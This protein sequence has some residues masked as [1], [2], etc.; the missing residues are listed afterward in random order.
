M[1]IC[2]ILPLLTL[3]A[4]SG[5]EALS[6]KQKRATIHRE[7]VKRYL[8]LSLAE[9]SKEENVRLRARISSLCRQIIKE[10][11]LKG[12]DKKEI[13]R[14]LGSPVGKDGEEVLLY[15]GDELSYFHHLF[16]NEQGKLVKHVHAYV[17]DAETGK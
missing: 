15:F 13:L 8:R 4:R 2:A 17:A 3:S 7:L 16:L 1:C 14:C 6:C 9:R 10:N 11:L 12:I 5:T